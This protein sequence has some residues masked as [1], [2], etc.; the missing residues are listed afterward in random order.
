M[1]NLAVDDPNAERLSS[2]CHYKVSFS[3]I[4]DLAMTLMA[5]LLRA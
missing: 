1:T 5:I 3:E 4:A 2:D